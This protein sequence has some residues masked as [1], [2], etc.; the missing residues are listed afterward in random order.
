MYEFSNFGFVAI[1][2]QSGWKVNRSN[3]FEAKLLVHAFV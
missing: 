2:V 1:S 3:R